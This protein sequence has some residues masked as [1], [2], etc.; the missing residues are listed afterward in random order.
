MLKLTFDS[1]GKNINFIRHTQFQD[2]KILGISQHQDL[3]STESTNSTGKFRV[4][5]KTK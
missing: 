1:D 3:K 5:F 2:P 4:K